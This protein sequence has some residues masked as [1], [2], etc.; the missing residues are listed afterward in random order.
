[1]LYEIKKAIMRH[2]S[3]GESARTEKSAAAFWKSASMQ[4]AAG[5]SI[6]ET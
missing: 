2:V 5:I 6:K 3:E 1:M 4:T